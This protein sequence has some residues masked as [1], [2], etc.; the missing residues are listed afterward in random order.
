MSEKPPDTTRASPPG[1]RRTGD[2][3]HR[4]EALTERAALDDLSFYSL[5]R[6]DADFIHQHVVDAWG[7]QTAT[8]D[9]RPVGLTMALVGLYLHVEHGF[10][11]RQVQRAHVYIAKRERAWPRFPLPGD[12]GAVRV[13][14]VLAAPPGLERDEAIRVWARAVWASFEASHASVREHV[15][16]WL[17]IEPP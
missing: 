10:T 1:P 4:A 6:G 8:E 9:D 14:D 2:E 15:R 5:S 7:A 17:D 13:E 3:E 11:G 16:A 12:R